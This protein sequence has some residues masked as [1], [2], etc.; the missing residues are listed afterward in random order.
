MTALLLTVIN[1]SFVL[2]DTAVHKCCR[3]TCCLKVCD[4][5]NRSHQLFIYFPSASPS[6]HACVRNRIQ[7]FSFFGCFFLLQ[8]P[9]PGN[10][11]TLFSTVPRYCCHVSFCLLRMLPKIKP[12][13][14]GIIHVNSQLST[15]HAVALTPSLHSAVL[16]FLRRMQ[17]C[18]R[19]TL[20][21]TFGVNINDV[22]PHRGMRMKDVRK[23]VL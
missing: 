23:A 1:I 6:V 4:K 3:L 17:K 12:S 5:V 2:R 14:P 21:L 10:G 8:F 18:K 19:F 16:S 20:S 11:F 22:V 7:L 13:L 15:R 9:H